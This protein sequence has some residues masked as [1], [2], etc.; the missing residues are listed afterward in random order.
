M[1][2][3]LPTRQREALFLACHG[4][5]GMV[6]GTK[7]QAAALVKKGLLDAEL[8][9]TE[10]GRQMY[11]ELTA[12]ITYVEW[13]RGYGPGLYRTLLAAQSTDGLTTYVAERDK[14]GRTWAVVTSTIP[15]L[16]LED[17][18]LTAPGLEVVPA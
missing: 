16:Q 15:T 5:L 9:P 17:W 1:N 11:A 13:L 7:D 14:A 12:P 8:Q 6:K 4:P 2:T 18:G 10:A 3:T